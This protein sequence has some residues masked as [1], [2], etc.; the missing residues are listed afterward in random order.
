MLNTNG[1]YWDVTIQGNVEE[2]QWVSD[3]SHL[4]PNGSYAAV[5]V[6]NQW[7]SFGEIPQW[8]GG[9]GRPQTLTAFRD[10]FSWPG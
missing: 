4:N 2:T 1:E 5:S 10:G 7:L 3:A 9:R 8:W 6:A